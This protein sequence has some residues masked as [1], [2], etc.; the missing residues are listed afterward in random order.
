LRPQ[1]YALLAENILV[2]NSETV[3]NA[4]KLHSFEISHDEKPIENERL[5]IMDANV[6]AVEKQP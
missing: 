4:D 3:P 6:C 1:G 2:D 5:I